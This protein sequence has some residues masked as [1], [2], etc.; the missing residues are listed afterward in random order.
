MVSSVTMVS[1]TF[2]VASRTTQE[3]E[4]QVTMRTNDQ[5]NVY[6]H[7]KIIYTRKESDGT[8]CMYLLIIRIEYSVFQLRK[9]YLEQNLESI[10]VPSIESVK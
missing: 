3:P 2:P 7:F 10:M 6:L 8:D 1:L 4:A 9:L 5:A